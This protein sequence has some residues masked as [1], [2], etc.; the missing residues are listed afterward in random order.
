MRDCGDHYEYIAR[1]VDDLAIASKDRGAITKE[2][3]EKFKFKLKGTGPITYNLGCDF[4]RDSTRTLCMQPKKYI[5]RMEGTYLQMF[6]SKPKTVYSS[7]IEKGDHLELDTSE[8][9]NEK[10][11]QQYQSLIGAAQWLV[12]LGRFDIATAVM[13]MSSFRVAPRKGHL[14]RMRRLYGYVKKMRHGCIRFRTELPDYSGMP[15]PDNQWAKS[16]YGDC[17]EQVPKDA[18]R[19]LGKP[20]IMTTYD[21]LRRCQLMS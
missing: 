10:G 18:P 14:E 7:P 3:M 12:T 13:K 4:F 2:L 5:E 21:H 19:P 15:V 17:K 20:V 11:I 8:E 6:G 9:I 16:M 1:Y